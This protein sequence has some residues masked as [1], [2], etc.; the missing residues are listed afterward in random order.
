M[1]SARPALRLACCPAVYPARCPLLLPPTRPSVEPSYATAANHV[2]NPP[3]FD[4]I[5]STGARR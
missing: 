3:D 1:S 4:D 5:R 2:S